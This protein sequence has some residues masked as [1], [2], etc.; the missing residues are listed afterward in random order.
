MLFPSSRENLDSIFVYLL[1][2]CWN[3]THCHFDNNDIDSNEH[4]FAEF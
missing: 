4:E 3:G 1:A 2:N